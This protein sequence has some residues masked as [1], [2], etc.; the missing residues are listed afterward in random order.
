MQIRQTSLQAL[1]AIA[2]AAGIGAANAAPTLTQYRFDGNCED[3]AA[4]AEQGSFPVSAWLT[5]QDLPASGLAGAENFHSFSY[6]GSN[7]LAPFSVTLAGGGGELTFDPANE[8][9]SFSADFSGLLPGFAE[10][11]LALLGEDNFAFFNSAGDGGQWS[12]FRGDLA[13]A[14]DFGNNGVWRVPLPS[15]LALSLLGLA[16]LGRQRRRSA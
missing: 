6:S 4:A 14:D 15:A 5:L 9:H 3:C 7:L 11:A 13:L 1:A 10:V 12:I 2:L 16:L 8:D